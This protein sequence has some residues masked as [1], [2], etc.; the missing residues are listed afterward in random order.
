MQQCEPTKSWTP[1]I[2][3]LF[4]GEYNHHSH[5]YTSQR[6]VMKGNCN[7]SLFKEKKEL[8]N[9]RVKRPK[10]GLGLW[11]GRECWAA[12]TFLQRPERV[13]WEPEC[14]RWS[15]WKVT[16]LQ[17]ACF[18]YFLFFFLKDGSSRP[19]V[20]SSILELIPRSGCRFIIASPSSPFSQLPAHFAVP[21]VLS[22]KTFTYLYPHP[23][24]RSLPGVSFLLILHLT[25]N[26]ADPVESP[27]GFAL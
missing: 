12:W 9:N 26:D 2:F 14:R 24:H 7:Y 19:A 10:G 1:S 16:Q 23:H 8:C 15:R 17:H 27:E 4:I 21:L 5:H 11:G 25:I 18:Y 20:S 6:S 22:V 13:D 3:L